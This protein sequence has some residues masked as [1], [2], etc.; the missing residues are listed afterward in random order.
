MVIKALLVLLQRLWRLCPAPFAGVRE[1]TIYQALF[2][3]HTDSVWDNY[4]VATDD[5]TYEDDIETKLLYIHW[6]TF[7]FRAFL[8]I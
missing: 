8:M 3:P 6:W 7:A 1:H 5:Q 4:E 2:E